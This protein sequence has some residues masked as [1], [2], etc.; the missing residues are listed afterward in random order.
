MT[1]A[2]ATSLTPGGMMVLYQED[3]PNVGLVVSVHIDIHLV[4]E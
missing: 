4:I 1:T 2:E 3:K